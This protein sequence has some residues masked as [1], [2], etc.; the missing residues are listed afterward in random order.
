MTE[1]NFDLSQKKVN[2]L[3]LIYLKEDGK[4]LLLK[5]SAKKEMLPEKWLG[6]GGKLEPEED[7]TESA[8]REFLEE[9]GLKILNPTL[10][11]TFTWINETDRAGTLYIFTATE[12]EGSLLKKCN[13]GELYW[14]DINLVEELEHFAEH[15]K[16][17]LSKILKDD[18][19][20]YT[21]I[22]VYDNGKLLH[23]ADSQRYFDERHTKY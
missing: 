19:H 22:A 12:Y 3:T 1:K 11:G 5:R 8:K 7:L 17:F 13:E 10:R 9:T 21:G 4:V 23:Y 14:H 15:Q 6:L 18:N 16:L 2:P 20:F